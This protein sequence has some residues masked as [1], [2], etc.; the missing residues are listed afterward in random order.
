MQT[1]CFFQVLAYIGGLYDLDGV[2]DSI[3]NHTQENLRPQSLYFAD[4][5][6]SIS[7]FILYG[8]LLDRCAVS[9]LAEVRI[10]YAEDYE[11]GGN[12]IMYLQRVSNIIDMSISSRSVNV[13]L[14]IDNQRN[15]THQRRIE[16]KKGEPFNVSLASINQINHP[17]NGLIYALFMFP[18][19][20]V[21]SGQATREIPA[22]CTNLTFNAVSPHSSE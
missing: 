2:P 12:G 7:G 21:S 13:C 3:L 4:N 10:K 9:Q 16:V 8:G 15:C 18:G 22:K 19:S 5:N 17:V 11:D 1:E 6:A 20:A 14:C